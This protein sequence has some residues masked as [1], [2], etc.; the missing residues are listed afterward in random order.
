MLKSFPGAA[1][2]SNFRPTVSRAVVAGF[3]RAGE[4]VVDFS[5]GYGGRMLGCLSIARD[6]IG[7]EP[8]A[9]QVHGSRKMFSDL[10][11]L[12]QVTSSATIR[13]GCAE[14]ILPTLA[15][16]SASLVFS[17]PPYYDWERYSAQGTQSFVRYDSYNTWLSGFLGPVVHESRRILKRG[18]HFILNISGKERRP[19]RADVEALAIRSRLVLK[20]AI[21]MMLA[22]IP[23]LH[24][25]SSGAHKPE[26]L[27]IFQKQ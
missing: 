18:G 24:P 10:R 19:D 8:C 16:R 25:R 15:P 21:P 6:Y 14:D 17:S 12:G 3:T 26:L 5:S 1:S 4:T 11:R 22:R 2:V 20:S 13:R 7:I 23:Y 9:E 27:L